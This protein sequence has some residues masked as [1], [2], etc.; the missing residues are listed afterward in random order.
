[1]K[2]IVCYS[3]GHSSALVAIEVCRKFGS[4]DVILL[5]HDIAPDREDEDI[6]RFKQEVANYLGLPVTYANID[7]VTNPSELPDQFDVCRKA[8]AITS[9]KGNALCT[10]KL[11][12]EPFEHFLAV[13]NFM[14]SNSI[15][16]EDCIIYYG[17]DKKE[18]TR[19]TRRI[20]I[21]SSKGF[22]SDYPLALW[23]ERTIQSTLEIGIQPPLT[24]GTWK[25]ANCKGCLKGGILHWYVTFVNDK[26]AYE[27]ASK[28]EIDLNYSINK[29]T[30]D[31]IE[32]TLFLEELREY[33]DKMQSDGV[34]A[35]EHQSAKKFTVLLKDKYGLIAGDSVKPCEC[36]IN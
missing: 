34:L 32:Y 4:E 9:V 7:G 12:T 15:F 6:K 8:G 13:N 17:F 16:G 25:H 18:M 33:F 10:S 11:K 30:T 24:Y 29:V 26:D 35:S 36:I 2:H 23:K 5:N 27:K 20:G 3:G 28:L 22:K 21:L 14:G 31:K 19:V 1:M